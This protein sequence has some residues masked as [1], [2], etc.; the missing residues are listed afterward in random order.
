MSAAFRA[1]HPLCARCAS[2]GI[3]KPAEV[4]DHITPWPVC[5]EEMFFNESNLQA[6]CSSCNHEKGQEDKKLIQQWKQ[7]RTLGRG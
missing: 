5:G 1:S 6:L 2:K 4:T 3:I 7:L